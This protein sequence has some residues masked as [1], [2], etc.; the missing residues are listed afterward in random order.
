[1]NVLLI[2]ACPCVTH[3]SWCYLEHLGLGY[4][5]RVLL[6]HG[7]AVDV[8]DATWDWEDAGSTAGRALSSG[9]RY[10]LVGFSVNRSNFT[11]TIETMQRLRNGGF[12]GHLTFGGYFPTFHFEKVLTNFSEI[13]SI[14]LGYGE[15]TLLKL[16]EAIRSRQPL[17][18]IPGLAYRDDDGLVRSSPCYENEAFIKTLGIPVH[19]PRYGIARILTS[20]GCSWGC[21]FCCVNAFDTYNFTS[22]YHRRELGQVLEEVDLLVNQHDVRHIWLSDLDFVGRDHD[23]IEAFCDAMIRKDCGVRLEGDCRLDALNEPFIEKLARAGFAALAVG[24]ESFVDRQIR[25]YGKFRG[26]TI[27]RSAVLRV[28]EAVRRHGMLVRFGFIMFD[29]DTTVEELAL[30]HDTISSTVGYGTLDSIANKL[31]VLPGTKLE[32]DYLRDGANCFIVDIDEETRLKP[33]LYYTQYRFRDE[34]VRFLYEASFSYR[35]KVARLQQ[36][37]DRGLRQNGVSYPRHIRVLWALRDQFGPVF[38]RLLS[39]AGRD[40][41]RATSTDEARRGVDAMLVDLCVEAG[42]PRQALRAAIDEENRNPGD[43]QP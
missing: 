24:V 13:D 4:L 33:H 29:K 36:V 26:G 37:L 15:F 9:K 21:T 43:P 25:D 17:T 42:F 28:A 34:R 22:R 16:C 8:M 31:A 41:C 40:G 5:E 30:N 18:G 11:N 38:G 35:N 23:F 2:H 27:D 32:A 6:D 19:R 14:V 20:R 3:R 7:F 1:M 39:L 12:E 10:D